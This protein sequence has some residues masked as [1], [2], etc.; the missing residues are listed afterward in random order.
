M[1]DP[2]ETSMHSRRDQLFFPNEM[3]VNISDAVDTVDAVELGKDGQEPDLTV[4]VMTWKRLSSM[5]SPEQNAIIEHLRTVNPTS[6]GFL[7][8]YLPSPDRSTEDFVQIAPQAYKMAKKVVNDGIETIEVVERATSTQF[9]PIGAYEDFERLNEAMQRDIDKR[10]IVESGYR[11]PAY[12]MMVFLTLLRDEYD[13]D[14]TAT[15]KHAALPY[16]SEH[17]DYDNPATDV[18]SAD[19][20]PVVGDPESFE[21]MPEFA[22]LSRHAHEFGFTLSYPRG[23]D[24][25]VMYEPWHWRHRSGRIGA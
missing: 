10:V 16:Y 8:D 1:T 9:M 22:W 11:S 15:A 14:V 2:F 5:L 23:N 17:G 4:I 3:K 6:H 7:G 21:Q 24:K 20:L 25:G 19:I 18:Q 12:Q 13:Y